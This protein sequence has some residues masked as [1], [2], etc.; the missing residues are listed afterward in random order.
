M[1]LQA[2]TGYP[3]YFI[4]DDGQVWSEKSHKYL[5]QS[6][7]GSYYRVTLVSP[8]GDKVTLSV[9]R[10]V[11]EAFIPNPENKPHVNHIDENKENNNVNN[12]EWVTEAE[13]ANHGTRNA[14]ISARNREL[15]PHGAGVGGDHPE[16][17][18][19]IM[20][21]P[22]TQEE[23]QTFP[24]IADACRFLGIDNAQPNISAVLAGRRRTA[25]KYFWK[26]A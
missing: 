12:L 21:D 8:S 16:A 24:S 14:R 18:A 4:Q 13:N 10:L 26:R 20:C 23:L 17:T 3:G 15:F 19:I 22:R 25:Y 11:A 5:S 6:K 7:R 1:A 9:H 2:I